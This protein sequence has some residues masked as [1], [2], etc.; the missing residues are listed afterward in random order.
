MRKLP[1]QT[2]IEEDVVKKKWKLKKLFILL[3]FVV[4]VGARGDHTNAA[5]AINLF[6]L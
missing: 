5:A 6:F 1:P 4:Y 3:D 2:E